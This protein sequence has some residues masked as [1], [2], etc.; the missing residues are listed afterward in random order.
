M[1]CNYELFYA[2]LKGLTNQ[3]VI[4]EIYKQMKEYCDLLEE[5]MTKP[6]EI[7]KEKLRIVFEKAARPKPDKMFLF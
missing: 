6:T 7:Y 1:D 4:D 2:G 5:E 3:Q